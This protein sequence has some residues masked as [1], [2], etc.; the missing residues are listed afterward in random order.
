MTGFCKLCIIYLYYEK[1]QARENTQNNQTLC[2]ASA[3]L[4]FIMYAIRNSRW[5]RELAEALTVFGIWAMF[6]YVM[7]GLLVGGW[8]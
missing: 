7:I 2:I 3:D 4:D 1:E 6:A 8:S 5:M